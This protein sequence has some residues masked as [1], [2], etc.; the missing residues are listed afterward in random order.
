MSE[1]SPQLTWLKQELEA[2][3]ST[4]TLAYWHKPRFS[5]GHHPS[6]PTYDSL[7]RILYANDV[8]I[9]ANGHSH[10]YERYVPQDP[11]GKYDPDKGITQFVSGAGGANFQPLNNPI[12]NLATRQNHAFGVLELSLY[13]N[14]A[15]YKFVSVPGQQ[16]FS[17]RGTIN[18]R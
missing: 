3:K 7:W 8:E 18:C 13:S 1:N 6:D 14:S 4:C 17:D 10:S 2:N 15:K 9:V 5:S 12:D 16:T 11:D